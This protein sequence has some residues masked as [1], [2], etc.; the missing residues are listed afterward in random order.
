MDGRL[1]ARAGEG[2]HVA[3]QHRV[4]EPIGRGAHDVA[5]LADAEAEPAVERQP[6][7]VEQRERLAAAAHAP[8]ALA[9]EPIRDAPAAELREHRRGGEA[10]ER[11]VRAREAH[12]QVERGDVPDDLAVGLGDDHVVEGEVRVLGEIPQPRLRIARLE[13][14]VGD[15]GEG[16]LLALA[17]AA[18]HELVVG[19]ARDAGARHEG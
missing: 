12:G 4:R 11:H 7:G 14:A 3:A 15:R 8:E 13:R 16:A 1:V 9:H 19:A 17:G 6:E 2:P 18:E 5:E 10:L